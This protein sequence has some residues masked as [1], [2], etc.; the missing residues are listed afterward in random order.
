MKLVKD[1]R[2]DSAIL[3]LKG[4]F[5][6][7]VCNP[8]IEQI[9]KLMEE[10]VNAVVL[11]MRLIKFINSTGIGSMIK[12]R[13][14]L[15]EKNGDL[16]ISKPSKFVREALESLG[17]TEV[18]KIFEG[19]EEALSHFDAG[20]GIE[21]EDGSNIMV[22][23][24]GEATAPVIGRIRKLDRTQYGHNERCPYREERTGVPRCSD[25]GGSPGHEI[26]GGANHGRDW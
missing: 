25:F 1:I 23:L 2:G 19:D 24:M 18:L 7:F 22:H 21:M 3:T 11:N 14:K 10:E 5:D 26:P 13:R 20:D 9:D 6:S 12:C 16:V 15:R 4:E 8:F 17:L